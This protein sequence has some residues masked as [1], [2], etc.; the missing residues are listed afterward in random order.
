MSARA[1]VVVISVG[2]ALLAACGPPPEEGL[3]GTFTSDIVQRDTCRVFTAADGEETEL[4]TED[5]VTQTLTVSLLEDDEARVWLVGIPRG[6]E[7]NR[8]ILGTRDSKGGF[9]FSARETQ[10]NT[11]TGCYSNTVI[12][13]SLRIDD[14]SAPHLRGVDPCVALTGRETRRFTT[15]A[16]CDDVNDPPRA[17]TRVNRKRWER[18]QLCGEDEE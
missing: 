6:G 1:V 18:P 9:L 4:C 14:L 17:V 16:E 8:R 15:S 7:S 11:T 10:R 2:V 13:L 12:E 5:D 3:I